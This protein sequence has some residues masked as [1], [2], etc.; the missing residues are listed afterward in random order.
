MGFRN[1]IFLVLLLLAAGNLF[2]QQATLVG[3]VTDQS[4]QVLVGATITATNTASG[5]ASTATTDDHGFYRIGNLQPGTYRIEAKHSGF[6]NALA[7]NVQFLVGQNVTVPFSMK[8]ASVAS[9]VEVNAAAE[10]IDTQTQAVS[11]NVTRQQMDDIPL[12]GRNW[13]DLALLVKGVVANDTH[14]NSAGADRTDQFQISL[15]GQQ[16]SQ[17]I[18]GSMA[19]G[20]PHL[21]RDAIA[22]FQLNT[23]M[24]DISLGRS[25]SNQL[26]AISRG[27]TNDIHGSFYGNFRRDEFNAADFVAHKVLPYSDTILGGTFGGPIIKNQLF[28]FVNY[29]HESTP[30]TTVYSPAPYNGQTLILPTTNSQY[31]ILGRFDWHLNDRNSISAHGTF[32]NQ[33][34]VGNGTPSRYPTDQTAVAYRTP[35]GYITW[36]NTIS[37]STVQ[38]FRGGFFEYYWK[39][40]IAPG[41]TVMPALSVGGI[42]IGPNGFYPELFHE[43]IPSISWNLN[44]RMGRHEFKFG[45]EVLLRSDHGDWPDNSRGSVGALNPHDVAR[46]FP[47]TAWNNPS[48]WDVSGL[49]GTTA[50]QSFYPNGSLIDVPRKTFALWV[51]D[52]WRPTNRLTINFGVRWDADFGEYNPAGFENT[53]VRVDNGYNAAGDWGIRTGIKSMY[54]VAPR[55][56]ASFLVGKGFVIRAGGG[57]FYAFQDSEAALFN[58]QQGGYNI[59][60]NNYTNSTTNPQPDF[61]TNWA[62]GATAATYV[63]N[64]ALAGPQSYGTFAYDMRDPRSIQGTLGFQKQIGSSWS[65]DSDLIYNKGEFLGWTGDV[66]AA[67]DPATRYPFNGFLDG[68][69]RPNAAW[70]SISGYF[71]NL[72]SNYM[73]LAS[74]LNHRFS[75]NYQV[76][77]TYTLLFF[78]NDEGSGS[79]GLGLAG[80]GSVTNAANAQ[81]DWGRASSFQRS[82]LR[83]NGV[84]NAPYHVNVSG[85]F[86]YGSG[87]YTPAILYP[88]PTVDAY[89]GGLFGDTRVCVGDGPACVVPDRLK[90]RWQG[91]TTIPELGLLPRSA[92][93]NFPFYKLDLR[94][95]RDFV[96]HERLKITPQVEVFNLF[97]H[98]NYGTYQNEFDLSSYGNP[99]ATRNNPAAYLPRE[100]QFAFHVQF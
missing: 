59:F 58:A 10:L 83:V 67:I 40:G 68:Y 98:P 1:K 42:T 3:T 96:V 66:N 2:G 72:H 11:G 53:H 61:L 82:T 86:S 27:G 43:N 100:F 14:N 18:A 79:T 78:S 6:A 48:A 33:Q 35:T 62:Q 32:F 34:A 70:S 39:T 49:V 51:G 64:P 91:P 97:N 52:T 88:D 20:E 85:L 60:S 12:L 54:D 31:N 89:S 63:A 76:S 22:E 57:V 15:D 81:L 17:Q 71:S 30:S 38:E 36:T 95:S 44:H 29:E 93:H 21:S 75:K 7:D 13:Q 41:V 90:S 87:Q 4:N 65:V 19:F 55:L 80:F 77:A 99:T 73:A 74:S 24:Y 94:L 9:T 50:R 84:Y 8:V 47:L 23:S 5:V 92:L 69:V 37:S 26:Q 45:A 56:G 25:L 28:Y 16:I 46:R